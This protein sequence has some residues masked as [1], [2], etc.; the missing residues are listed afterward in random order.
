[1]KVLKTNP[2]PY[3]YPRYPLFVNIE[4]LTQVCND[5]LDHV[6]GFRFHD[7]LSADPDLW[8]CPP[9]AYKTR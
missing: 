9:T 2:M 5:D 3:F 7:S 4:T 6:A 1:M 8:R